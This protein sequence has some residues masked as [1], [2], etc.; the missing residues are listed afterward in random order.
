MM[1]KGTLVSEMLG[2][3]DTLGDALEPEHLHPH[4]GQSA[5]LFL[6]VGLFMGILTMHGISRLV[7]T[8]PYTSVLFLEGSLLGM[9]SAAGYVWKPLARSITIWENIDPH[10]LFYTFLPVLVFGDAMGLN[11]HLFNRCLPQ[12]LVLAVPG[13]VFNTM[14]TA[15][16]VVYVLPYGFDWPT[17][18]A[19]GAILSATDPVAVVAL[20]KALGVSPRLTMLISGESLLNDGTGIVL[21]AL[22]NKIILGAHVT[23][24]SV[25]QFL[26]V[27][28]GLAPVLGLIFGMITVSWI[29]MVRRKYSEGDGMCQVVLTILCAYCSFFFAESVFSTS[30]VLTTV[31]AGCVLASAGTPRLIEP[32]VVHHVWHV[33]EY[34]ANTLIF[35]LAGLI[36]GRIIVERHDVIRPVDYWWLLGLYFG[37]VFI[38]GL[39]VT[40]MWPLLRLVGPAISWQEACVLTWS[41][42]RGAVGLAL[43]IMMDIEPRIDHETG[44]RVM[45]MVGGIAA[46]TLIVNGTTTRYLLA[47]L[48]IGLTSRLKEEMLLTLKHRLDMHLDTALVELTD[49]TKVSKRSRFY[50]A[51][52]SAVK[53]ALADE[54]EDS[55]LDALELQGAAPLDARR[56]VFLREIFLHMVRN[57]YD[58]GVEEGSIDGTS[59]I[60]QTLFHSV[61][62]TLDEIH[63]ELHDWAVLHEQLMQR[64]TFHNFATVLLEFWPFDIGRSELKQHSSRGGPEM[65]AVAVLSFIDAHDSAL[66]RLMS[67]FGATG[68]SQCPEEKTIVAESTAQ[69]LEA[70]KVL[71]TLP[72]ELVTLT[73]SKMLAARLSETEADSI[74]RMFKL[75]VLTD[76]EAGTM[77]ERVGEKKAKAAH[78]ITEYQRAE[79]HAK[80]C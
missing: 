66:Q 79:A 41:G 25:I 70:E 47:Y 78:I 33:I 38:R 19:L 62:Q 15:G 74:Q 61:D 63:V 54:D 3:P 46:L 58:H 37:L 55:G 2:N 1:V 9:A 72:E 68:A 73:R 77:L 59:S 32:H 67:Y 52:L 18:I 10:L 56:L 13:V 31:T 42:L 60:V 29:G 80:F 27:M 12:V 17:S 57:A 76:K 48:E 36:V 23:R 53:E 4:Q 75:G 22:F 64:P 51:D 65:M 34:I 7:P 44:T 40:V 5:L 20:F 71:Q 16:F 30:G 39:G 14:A 26:L 6:C 50:G 24:Q 11:I 8:L 21:F 43:A 45:F 28:V 49:T 35:L 69:M